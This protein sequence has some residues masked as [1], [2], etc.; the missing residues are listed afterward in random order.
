MSTPEHKLTYKLPTPRKMDSSGVD[1]VS[2][3]VESK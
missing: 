3:P 2:D 1:S